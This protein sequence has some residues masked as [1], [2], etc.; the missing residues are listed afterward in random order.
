MK[1]CEETEGTRVYFECKNEEKQPN[2]V[3]TTNNG[4]RMINSYT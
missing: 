4:A 2:V 1:E 3:Q